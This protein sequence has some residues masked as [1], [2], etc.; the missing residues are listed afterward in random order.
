MS[1]NYF[2][3]KLFIK[4]YLEINYDLLSKDQAAK[5]NSIKEKI[6]QEN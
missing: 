4:L 3:P 6:Y 2:G 1:D 5:Y